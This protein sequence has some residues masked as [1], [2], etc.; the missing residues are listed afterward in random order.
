M[1]VQPLKD[2]EWTEHP[3]PLADAMRHGRKEEVRHLIEGGANIN[4]WDQYG[5]TAF[6]LAV[7][8]GYGHL[9]CSL[10][11]EA[12][13]KGKLN[14]R[15][16]DIWGATLLTY[17]AAESDPK[18]I[19]AL[20]QQAEHK[21]LSKRDLESSLRVSAALGNTA[22][23]DHL[24]RRISLF[25]KASKPDSTD[26]KHIDGLGRWEATLTASNSKPS[27]P[28][29][30]LIAMVTHGYWI[31]TLVEQS[32][33]ELDLVVEN[34][35]GNE[36]GH[37]LI[38]IALDGGHDLVALKLLGCGVRVDHKKDRGGIL[39]QALKR[40]ELLETAT[41]SELLVRGA[42]TCMP[43]LNDHSLT[44]VAC[45]ERLRSEKHAFG[46]LLTHACQKRARDMA[47]AQRLFALAKLCI[48]PA[49]CEEPGTALCASVCLAKHLQAYAEKIRLENVDMSDALAAMSV[50]V[51]TATGSLIATLPEAERE[52]LFRT[53][54]GTHFF[55]LASAAGLQHMLTSPAV[56]LHLTKRWVGP[57]LHAILEGEGVHRYGGGIYLAPEERAVLAALILPV[58]V[59]NLAALPLVA[60]CPPFGR[61]LQS[62]LECLGS[63]GINDA[64]GRHPVTMDGIV[65]YVA[66]GYS[67]RLKLWWR[68]LYLLDVPILKF[69]LV[70]LC[71]ALLLA[72]LL[73]FVWCVD[74]RNIA[75]DSCFS[76]SMWDSLPFFPGDP[77]GAIA[78]VARRLKKGASAG[79]H[80][81]GQ[82]PLKE[83]GHI[84]SAPYHLN[85]SQELAYF[86]V[87]FAFASQLVGVMVRTRAAAHA[88]CATR[89]LHRPAAAMRA[90]TCRGRRARCVHTQRAG[91]S[92]AHTSSWASGIAAALVVLFFI[93][94]H[95]NKVYDKLIDPEPGM[96]AV[97]TFLQ[98]VDI[99]RAVLLQIPTCGPYVLMLQ[100]ML[101]DLYIWLLLL[102]A[103]VV[104]FTAAVYAK[105]TID[106]PTNDTCKDQHTYLAYL[107][108]MFGVNFGG[109]SHI[110]CSDVAGDHVTTWLFI[111]YYLFSMVL[112]MNML[113]AM[114]AKTFDKIFEEYA[115]PACASEPLRGAHNA[116]ELRPAVAQAGAQLQFHLCARRT[117]R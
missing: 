26:G 14:L 42:P 92:I 22:V 35:A 74:I 46:W 115:T 103:V 50:D 110:S 29:Q 20:L 65:G 85:V 99:S 96:V 30:A 71:N 6:M 13:V 7:E 54:S 88:R 39:L 76:D 57:L 84:S 87:I 34:T 21:K 109:D 101:R 8:H 64:S 106:P 37:T 91:G 3:K 23:V 28:S 114:M 52:L 59:V 89:P 11:S 100:N 66:S 16:E 112:L 62:A 94:D 113:I 95:F 83:A 17:A 31:D 77:V 79:P 51:G 32:R 86:V 98:T 80:E 56:T 2:V 60:L 61:L 19:E 53:A 36:E 97:A 44:T 82:T 12:K 104:A 78:R 5:K 105:N 111:V 90:D 69:W 25:D 75:P 108:M 10:C 63:D 49:F 18:L 117:L 15:H 93:F 1:D 38:E 68:A 33:G 24:V 40:G 116:C 45:D 43:H 73:L 70:Q 58:L 107:W 4:E 48:A 41:V 9:V 102:G 81:S 47:D 55:R 67:Q 72:T 27:S